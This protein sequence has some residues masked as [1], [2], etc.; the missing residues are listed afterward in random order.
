MQTVKSHTSGEGGASLPRK[1]TARG[2]AYFEAGDGETLILIHGVGM[3]LEAWAPQIEAFTK[4]HR[5][6]ALDMP[7]HGASKKIPAGSTMRDYVAWFGCFL[8][9]LSIARANIAGHSMGALISGGAAATFSD[10]ITR[11]AYLNGVYR[12]DAAAKAAVLARAEAIRKNGVDAEGPLVRWFGEDPKSQRARELTRTWL[13]MVDPEGY[14]T[15]YAAFAGG[16]EIYADCWPSVECPALFLTGSGDPNSTPEMA[17]Q[18]ASMTPKGWARIV[19]GH[20]HMVNLTAPDIVNA[21]MSEW[22]TS[23][24]KPR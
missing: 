13:E 5:V 11:V 9:D 1:T 4:T 22:L 2:A 8:D 7:G 10:R 19:D 23:R 17:K 21:Q 16:D 18:M 6:L 12:R 3:R 14:A 24:E 15:A 20:R